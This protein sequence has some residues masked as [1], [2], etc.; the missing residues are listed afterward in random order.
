MM[1]LTVFE[2]APIRR[3]EIKKQIAKCSHENR[4]LFVKMYGPQEKLKDKFFF[5]VD[6]IAEHHINEIIDKIPDHKLEW[7]RL[8]IERTLQRKNDE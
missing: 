7:A 6:A 2:V 3:A 4:A 5:N 8:Q 1:A